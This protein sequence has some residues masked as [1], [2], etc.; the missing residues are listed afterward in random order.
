MAAGAA[1]A[2]T[3][4]PVSAPAR[5][6]GR[7]GDERLGQPGR[8]GPVG[9]QR[10]GD[11]GRAGLARPHGE[12]RVMNAGA[13]CSVATA[14]ARARAWPGWRAGRAVGLALCLGLRLAPAAAGEAPQPAPAPVAPPAMAAAAPAPA[15]GDLF[16]PASGLRRTAYRAPVPG[17]P[18]GVPQLPLAEALR[19][20]DRGAA[21]FIDVMPVEDGVRDPVSG[22]WRL[23]QPRLTIP[24]AFWFP[25]V[26]RAEP[27]ADL[28][29][30][31]LARMRA[32]AAARPK[33]PLVLF[34]LA[35]CWMSWNAALRL[36]RLGI[37]PVVWLAEG[38]DGWT[39]SGRT[40]LPA[41]PEAPPAAAG[42]P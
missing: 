3:R 18:P 13:A 17:P 38:T 27:P 22:Q 32:L 6:G 7:R 37:G 36:Q 39:E 4:P 28:L 33:R 30:A 9:K 26:G 34:C 19:L 23:R 12:G 29:N 25:E 24:G 5:S 31:F 8:A 11:D 14:G 10:A 41:W 21:W 1:S 40:L 35:D 42:R 20:H 16:D 2:G 15:G